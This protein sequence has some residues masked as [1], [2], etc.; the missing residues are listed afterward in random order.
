MIFTSSKPNLKFKDIKFN[1]GVFYCSEKE[2]PAY[3]KKLK[4]VDHKIPIKGNDGIIINKKVKNV[5]SKKSKSKK[6]KS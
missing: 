5:K 2:Y 1:D 3:K 4:K 6:T